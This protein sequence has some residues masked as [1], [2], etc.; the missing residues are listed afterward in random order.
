MA[1][2][3]V[4]PQNL[5][6]ERA[7]LGAALIEPETLSVVYGISPPEA[8]YRESHRRIYQAMLE[9]VRANQ[10][11]DLLTLPAALGSDLQTVGGLGY[12]AQLG[13]VT[14]HSA[15]AEHYAGLVRE[16]WLR[17]RM[18]QAGTRV[19]QLARDADKELA[20]A[21]SEAE[22]AV[23]QVAATAMPGD[24]QLLGERIYAHF[25]RPPADAETDRWVHSGVPELDAALGVVGGGDL[26]VLA[27]RPG[28]G[29][30]ALALQLVQ[31]L[32][33]QRRPV[34]LVSLEMGAC[35]LGERLAVMAT[36]VDA[37]LLKRRR[38]PPPQ[39]ERV[40]HFLSQLLTQ[41]LF[42]V[43]SAQLTTLELRS[44]ARRVKAKHGLALVVVDYLQLLDVPDKRGRNRQEVVAEIAR[45]L[46][47]LARELQ[48]PVLALSQ[49]SREAERQ[50]D[51]APQLWNL[52]ESGAIEQDADLV[53]FLHRP[54][55][56]P[57]GEAIKTE[58]RVEKSRHGPRGSCPLVFLPAQIRFAA[59]SD[60]KEGDHGAV[61]GAPAR[62]ADPGDTAADRAHRRGGRPRRSAERALGLGD[63]GPLES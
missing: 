63:G 22:A 31:G 41:P 53:A 47:A 44:R 15:H 3:L 13:Q 30:T 57:Q 26:V 18:L 16:A 60:R 49:L 10:P 58:L 25:D 32:A 14:P 39:W 34:L 33:Q 38:L 50:D 36:G 21:L 24:P 8:F 9:L 29:K 59:W 2:E 1:P 37:Q 23:L 40:S 46:K 42:V 61:D 12:L 48:V 35:Q 43:D 5:E 55:K 51:R 4:P 20:Q 7:V 62:A 28:V 19:L 11:L 17:R 52:R 56:N 54:E 27:A 6:A 45:A